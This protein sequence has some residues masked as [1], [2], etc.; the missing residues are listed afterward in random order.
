MG[1]NTSN[2]LGNFSP[3]GTPVVQ[4]PE[5]TGFLAILNK[6][7]NGL[8]ESIQGLL[9]GT[10][11]GSVT[12]ASGT[13]TVIVPGISATSV[14]TVTMA[15]GAT[16]TGF[17]QVSFSQNSMTITSTVDTDAGTVYYSGKF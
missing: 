4:L 17:L 8:F 10:F 7:L 12:M 6:K 14:A 2:Q 9:N 16:Q 13:A 1:Q 3:K 15:I 11:S 5:W